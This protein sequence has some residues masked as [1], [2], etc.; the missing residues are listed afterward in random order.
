MP[1]GG[2]A[3]GTT[4]VNM[5]MRAGVR[6]SDHPGGYA[7]RQGPA[8]RRARAD[9]GIDLYNLFNTSD[10]FGFVETYDY[11][12]NGATYLRPNAIVAPRFVRFNVTV[13]F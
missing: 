12:T 9:I 5:L 6:R 7:I 4:S 2:L 11:A 8:V 13:N 10:A 1:A 3:T